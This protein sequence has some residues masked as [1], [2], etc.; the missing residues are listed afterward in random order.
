MKLIDHNYSPRV[1]T[2]Q[3]QADNLAE[4]YFGELQ[5]AHDYILN[6]GH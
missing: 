6:Y 4:L 2:R 3:E 1:Y 5:D